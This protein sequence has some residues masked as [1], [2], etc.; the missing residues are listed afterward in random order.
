MTLSERG[1]KLSSGLADD[2]EVPDRR[3]QAPRGIGAPPILER[4]TF[5]DAVDPLPGCPIAAPCRFSQGHRLQHRLGSDEPMKRGLGG[6]VDLPSEY[7]LEVEDQL[8]LVVGGGVRS[9]LDKEIDI[10][11]GVGRGSSDGPKDPDPTGFVLTNK[12]SDLL[13]VRADDL[14]D[15]QTRAPG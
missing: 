6:H 7:L 9:K 15:A 3:I 13:A 10:A 2:L 4:R 8:H 11:S 5:D 12:P 1:R 14:R